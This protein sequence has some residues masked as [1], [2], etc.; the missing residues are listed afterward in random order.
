MNSNNS[1]NGNDNGNIEEKTGNL[2]KNGDF[3]NGISDWSFW[4]NDIGAGS[5]AVENG[6]L[7]VVISNGGSFPWSVGVSQNGL[8]MEYGARY[9][10][11][12]KA[13]TDTVS[14]VRCIVEMGRSPWT[15]YSNDNYFTLTPTMTEYSYSFTINYPTDSGADFQFSLGTQGLGSVYIDNV[16]LR[17]ISNAKESLPPSD[18]ALDPYVQ[19]QLLSKCINMGNY[20]D[21]IPPEGSWQDIDNTNEHLIQEY[22]FSLIKNKGFNSVRIPIRFSAYTLSNQ[23]YT[24]QTELLQ[25]V[26]QVVNW[27]LNNDLAVIIDMHCYVEIYTD[28]YAHKE[29][30]ITIWKQLA[31]RYKSYPDN[32]FFELLNEPSENLTASIWND[33]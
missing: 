23:P 26:D 16:V 6:E 15:R 13:R 18:G 8:L 33:F 10:V 21:S 32:V 2:L 31:Q 4:T 30:F 11:T 1:N 14:T 9:L 27:A 17:K 22:F 19:V 29:R 5:M 24:I 28:P 3:S 20:L 12:F 25:R 7:H